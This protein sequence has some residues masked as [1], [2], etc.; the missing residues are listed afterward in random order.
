LTVLA[1]PDKPLQQVGRVCPWSCPCLPPRSSSPGCGAPH[2][3]ADGGMASETTDDVVLARN[4]ATT[5]A[6]LYG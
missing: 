3:R 1:V 5:N 6:I 2:E 4:E